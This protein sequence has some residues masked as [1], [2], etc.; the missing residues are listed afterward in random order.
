MD[1][2]IAE[3][4]DEDALQLQLARFAEAHVRCYDSDAPRSPELAPD[5]QI[6][7][8]TDD[9]GFLNIGRLSNGQFK[10]KWSA[11]VRNY[12]HLYTML[13]GAPVVR[14]IEPRR[15]E[16]QVMIW[17]RLGTGHRFGKLETLLRLDIA[18]EP[19]QRC[20]VTRI[21]KSDSSIVPP[22]AEEVRL[23]LFKMAKLIL[24]TL[25]ADNGAFLPAF[26]E[27]RHYHG[28]RMRERAELEKLVAERSPQLD[29]NRLRL[30]NGPEV[31]RHD[32]WLHT[33]VFLAE[34]LRDLPEQG[35]RAGHFCL[36]LMTMHFEKV[37]PTIRSFDVRPLPGA[38]AG[39]QPAI[40]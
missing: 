14:P 38:P 25:T 15:Y 39:V 22:N 18:A 11:Y 10:E 36:V 4:L 37:W 8:G 30:V 32:T 27:R 31:F 16:A 35:V 33:G 2:P 1:L 9:S 19:G 6:E 40:K 17:S 12:P 7:T 13:L 3:G 20:L 28:G 21:R 29:R 34:A 24:E 23:S 26:F 5:G